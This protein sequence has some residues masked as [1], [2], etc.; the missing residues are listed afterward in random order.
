MND[1]YLNWV[2]KHGVRSI[3]VIAMTRP[4]MLRQAGLNPDE[5]LGPFVKIGCCEFFESEWGNYEF[6]KQAKKRET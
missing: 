1:Q 4:D 5:D 6:Y 2:D 3:D